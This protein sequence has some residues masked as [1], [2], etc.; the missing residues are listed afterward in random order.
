MSRFRSDFDHIWDRLKGRALVVYQPPAQPA[1]R[2]PPPSQPRPASNLTLDMALLNAHRFT[3]NVSSG[4][5]ET[6]RLDK[7]EVRKGT[8]YGFYS[9]TCRNRSNGMLNRFAWRCKVVRG[10]VTIDKTYSTQSWR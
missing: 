2:R 5:E 7:V 3:A 8:A 4:R 9:I 10:V 1:F 6:V